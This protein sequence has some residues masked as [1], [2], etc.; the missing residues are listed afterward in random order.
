MVVGGLGQVL[1]MMLQGRCMLAVLLQIAREFHCDFDLYM[2]H[3]QQDGA[4]GDL[5]R[6][7]GRFLSHRT[8]PGMVKWESST[9]RS[10]LTFRTDMSRPGISLIHPT[11]YPTVRYRGFPRRGFYIVCTRSKVYT[12]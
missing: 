6:G 9:Q 8:Q 10:T 11:T 1:I 4:A 3:T 7:S 2:Y 12:S 5:V